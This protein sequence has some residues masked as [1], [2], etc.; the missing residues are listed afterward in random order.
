[1][2]P[3]LRSL[4][5]DPTAPPAPAAGREVAMCEPDG[6][7][8]VFSVA[9][10]GRLWLQVPGIATFAWDGAAERLLARPE[11][12]VPEDRILDAYR[13]MALPLTHQALGWEALH[14]SAVVAGEHV[15]AICAQTGTGKSTT[16]YGL[17]RRGMALWADD[18]VLLDAGPGQAPVRCRPVPFGFHLRDESRRALAADPGL[19][20]VAYAQ[21]GDRD[22]GAVL[23][24]ERR[25]DPG[26]PAV[27]RLPGPDAL[28]ALLPHGYRFGLRDDQRRRRT[29]RH[30]LALVA[31][32]PVLRVRFTPGWEGFDALLDAIEERL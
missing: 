7:P 21:G 30:Y 26:P 9:Q 6:S 23:A 17:A 10:D 16:A 31:E 3:F 28:T 29:M 12:G 1:M 13:T 4:V 8:T 5:I 32:V 2:P 25:D 24:L 19:A 18:V 22:L 11:P 27:E 14:A 20:D 15:V